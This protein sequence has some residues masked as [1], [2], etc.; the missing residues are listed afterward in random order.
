MPFGIGAAGIVGV[1]FETTAGTY[2]APA[3]FMPL[4]SESLEFNQEVTKRRVIRG[5][6]DPIGSVKGNG[7]VGGDISVEVLPDVLPWF[8]YASRC[9]VVKTGS[10]PYT[11]VATGNSS[12]SPTSGRTLSITI[13]RN[14]V[15]FGYTGCIVA[16]SD[17]SV[18]DG[19]LQAS[20][21]IVGM[22]EATQSSPT[23][24]WPTSV[25]FGMGTYTLKFD[26][27]TDATVSDMT[28][29][30][31]DN[32]Q[33]EFRLAGTTGADVVRFGERTTKISVTRDFIDRTEYNKYRALT[34]ENFDLTVLNGTESVRYQ[35]PVAVMDS[36]EI[37]MSNPGDMIRAKIDF[38]GDYD[39]TTT[40]SWKITVV[41]N[42]ENIT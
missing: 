7:V 40:A 16:S 15:V 38:M 41:A 36:Y 1:A 32:G 35:I 33:A 14:G 13:V 4:V 23:P 9:T 28:I 42:T 8:L 27:V 26:T 24:T 2:V 5:T 11:Y 12:G 25:P 17:Y 34:A 3:K 39:A 6:P 30:I 31:D 21:K 10:G 20:H 29:S 19:V 18:K 37:G 22:D